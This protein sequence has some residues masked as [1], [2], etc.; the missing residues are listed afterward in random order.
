MNT[1]FLGA[2]GFVGKALFQSISQMNTLT[3][4]THHEVLELFDYELEQREH[5]KR[6]RT[7]EQILNGEFGRIIDC[8]WAGLPDIS[9]ENNQLNFKIK[10]K[11]V[12][13]FA[14]YN[15][16]EYVGFGSCLEYGSIT[17]SAVENCEGVQVGQFGQI[18]LQTLDLIKDSG[19]RYKW[20]RPFYLIGA[21]Q[22]PNSLLR[23]AVKA[24][25]AGNEFMP[26]DPSITNDYIPIEEAVK[27]IKAVIECDTPDGI[28]NVG[29]GE[30]HSVNDL[31]N[32]VRHN[33]GVR[34]RDIQTEVGM[35]ADINKLIK[36]TGYIPRIDFT[37]SVTRIIKEI[38]EI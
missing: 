5:V 27:M 30:G 19:I 8:S 4:L 20:F 1:L 7:Y 9:F 21:R 32:I 18:K 36:E 17:G 29:S 28:Y 2:S 31:V 6:F 3:V 10:E 16:Q 13:R 25:T 22:H 23:L 26:R 33:F 35:V 34:I 24:M 14:Q 38:R 15:V 12:S 37:E 11:L